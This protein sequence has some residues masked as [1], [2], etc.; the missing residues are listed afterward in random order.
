[1]KND[2]QTQSETSGDIQQGQKR[3]ALRKDFLYSLERKWYIQGKAQNYS[4]SRALRKKYQ[5]V[6][7][8]IQSEFRLWKV[9]Y[10]HLRPLTIK[11][12]NIMK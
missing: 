12:T 1:M 10:P 4:E 8:V 9:L 5:G 3:G 2:N 11:P 7:Q 6:I